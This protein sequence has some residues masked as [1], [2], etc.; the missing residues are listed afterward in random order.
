MNMK[1]KVWK[2]C[3][4]CGRKNVMKLKRNFRDEYVVKGY[5]KIMIG[6]LTGYF[7]PFCNDG[8]L[9]RRSEKL[10]DSKLGEHCARFD[11][12]K[13]TASQLISVPEAVE[14]LKTSR[15]WV[16]KLMI[17]GQLDYVFV[18]NLRIPQKKAVLHYHDT[19]KGLIRKGIAASTLLGKPRAAAKR[20]SSAS[21]K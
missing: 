19:A 13:T 20:K 3:P 17:D 15:Q 14:I 5:P 10:I 21:K 16:H 6:P 7:C 2:N 11:S 12:A 18:G 1:D 8:F 9:T 4:I